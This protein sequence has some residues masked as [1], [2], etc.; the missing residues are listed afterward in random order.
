MGAARYNILGASGSG[1]STFGR[2]LAERL[3]YR[4]IELDQLFWRPGWVGATDEVFFADVEE[5]TAGEGWVL[6]G[7]YTRTIPI[8]WRQPIT[9]IWL[10]YPLWLV[11]A[12][13]IRRCIV[14]AWRQEDVWPGI[15]NRESFRKSFF[16]KDSIILWS[17]KVYHRN[18]K[19]LPALMADPE[20]SQVTWRR[21][22][23]P[24][25]AKSYLAERVTG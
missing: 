18:K 10:D 1:K 13:I 23:S 25:E 9:V 7:G 16:S 22:R 20:L 3:G 14:R 15:G 17:W 19:A 6:D 12:R 4:Y 21:L 2:A 5:A 8:K 24:R 11:M